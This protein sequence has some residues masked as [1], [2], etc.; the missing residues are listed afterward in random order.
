MKTST[1]RQELLETK[2][3]IKPAKNKATFA[4]SSTPQLPLKSSIDLIVRID[5]REHFLIAGEFDA[6]AAK[7]EILQRTRV[8]LKNERST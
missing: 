5:P 7:N 3:Q 1:T 8:N 6:P 2:N 4:W